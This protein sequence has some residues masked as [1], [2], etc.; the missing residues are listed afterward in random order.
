M[1]CCLYILFRR[2][3]QNIASYHHMASHKWSF[4]RKIHLGI[5]TR[6]IVSQSCCQYTFGDTSLNSRPH[7]QN[8][9][10]DH[11]RRGLDEHTRW[12]LGRGNMKCCCK[13][14][15]P[16]RAVCHYMNLCSCEDQILRKDQVVLRKDPA[17]QATHIS[18]SRSSMVGVIQ[19]PACLLNKTSNH[20]S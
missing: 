20:D 10:G 1:L 5:C 9:A 18:I 15:S 11:R 6:H 3:C 17:Q 7:P 16:G 2:S 8:T 12:T 14:H 4:S 13:P 19:E